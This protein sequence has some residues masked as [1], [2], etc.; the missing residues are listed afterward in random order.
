MFIVIILERRIMG[1]DL[2]GRELGK[3]ISQRKNGAYEARYIDPYGIRRS[4]YTTDL[5]EAKKK[6][7]DKLY[8]KEH[9]ISVKNDKM[10]LDEWYHKWM[11][12]YKRNSIKRSSIICYNNVYNNYIASELGK[13]PLISITKIQIQKLINNM[14]DNGYS[15]AVQDKVK[16]LLTDMY[17]RA[18]EDEFAI[19]NPVKGIR[20]KGEKGSYKVLT[21][22]EQ[23]MFFETAAGTFYE[24]LFIVA[25][26]TGLRSAELFA[27]TRDDIDFDKKVIHVRH[28]LN[29]FKYEGDEQKTFHWETP[30]TKNSLRDVPINSICEEYLKRQ[31][32]LKNRLSIKFP[33]NSEFSKVI[34]VSALNNP[35]N[36]SLY[37][38]AIKRIV[39]MRNELLDDIEK[40][41]C[42]GGHTFRHTFA[43]RCIEAGVKPKTLQ[44]YLGHATLQMTMDLYVHTMEETKQDEIKL[45][46][47]TTIDMYKFNIV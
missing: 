28:N 2:K 9:H 46:E 35:L 25:V 5:K 44:D 3:G 20:L 18:I 13:F 42:F 39:D 31:I 33:N 26:N 37:H 23:K 38:E 43:T 14:Y 22:E 10:T 40:M 19:R 15:W 30:K 41:E 47:D 27:L 36:T 34:F 45:L 24:N 12:V 6:L 7:L 16:R 29:Y 8:E 17:G 32:R 1:K 4:I 21:K 11:D